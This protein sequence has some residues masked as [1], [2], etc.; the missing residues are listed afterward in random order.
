MNTHFP[1]FS[2]VIPTY[3]RP[4]KVRIAIAS[5]LYQIVTDWELLVVDDGSSDETMEILKKFPDN[6]IKYCRQEHKERSAARNLGISNSTGQY[7]CFLDDDDYFERDHL[8]TFMAHISDKQPKKI[9]RSGYVTKHKTTKKKSPL[10]S[11]KRHKHPVNFFAHHMCGIWSLCIP[12]EFLDNHQFPLN[13][14]H[15]QDTHLALR[16]LA[17]YPFEQLEAWTYVYCQHESMGSVTFF[18]GPQVKA[19]TQLQID[20]IEDLFANHSTLLSPILA[21]STK[22][23]L[24]AEKHLRASGLFREQGAIRD[25][26]QMLREASVPLALVPSGIKHV[27]KLL[28]SSIKKLPT[29]ASNTITEKYTRQNAQG[30]GRQCPCCDREFKSFK[31]FGVVKRADA[32]CWYCG[33][34]ERHRL[35]W[36][37]C[38]KELKLFNSIKPLKILH[39]GPSKI[40]YEQFKQQKNIDYI[41]GDAAPED[42]AFPVTKMDLTEKSQIK[43]LCDLIFAIHVLEHI[44]DEAAAMQTIYE[45]LNPGGT[46]LIMIPMDESRLQTK[47]MGAT[48]SP[49][50]RQKHFGQTDHVRVYGKDFGDR[51][52]RHGFQI[53]EIRYASQLTQ[54]E[55]RRYAVFEHD[56]IFVCRKDQ[57][58]S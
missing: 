19:R 9:L 13:F 50:L 3:N 42:Y 15:W 17:L 12:R 26:W 7:I 54:E 36:L 10:Y 57:N 27:S 49:E 52:L 32:Q 1:L 14:P 41:A 18:K 24:I 4:Q 5:V 38:D 47:E 40:F 43:P 55:L 22:K 30:S 53:E 46:A 20:A 51:L 37:Y 6:R 45:L 33:S 35:L 8:S 21:R 34:L 31:S 39:I 29:Y 23:H 56:I 25:S 58:G 48:L 11:K 16:L 44:V 28:L 2:I